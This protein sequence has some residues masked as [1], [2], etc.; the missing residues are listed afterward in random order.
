MKG[1][2]IINNSSNSREEKR[3][4]EHVIQLEST[5]HN[6]C[7]N[8]SLNLKYFTFFLLNF[9]F[10]TYSSHFIVFKLKL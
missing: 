7:K 9:E 10:L 3:Y 6:I 4:C 1:L 2:I 5:S 8:E